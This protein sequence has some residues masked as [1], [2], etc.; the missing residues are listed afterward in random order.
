MKRILALA[1][2]GIF[3]LSSASALYLVTPTVNLNKPGV[4]EKL[5]DSHPA[6][7]E[8]IGKILEG[9]TQRPF[10][11]VPRWITANFDARDAHFS[12]V[13][14]TSYPPQREIVFVFDRTR[15]RARVKLTPTGARLTM[16]E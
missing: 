15:Y 7:Y 6:H 11:D 1:C 5:R 2:V 3:Y 10:D 8:K 14:M 4:L 9:L 13:L 16:Y 12:P